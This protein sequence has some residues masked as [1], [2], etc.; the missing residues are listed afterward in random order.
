M[1]PLRTPMSAPGGGKAEAM[2]KLEKMSAALQ[3]TPDAEKS[4]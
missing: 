2:Q 4:R 1:L 3:L